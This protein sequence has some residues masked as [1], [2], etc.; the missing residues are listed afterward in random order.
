MYSKNTQDVNQPK[1]QSIPSSITAAKE[2]PVVPIYDL[3][4]SLAERP[5]GLRV[6]TAAAGQSCFQGSLEM[7]Q[8][9]GFQ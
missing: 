6:L 1:R 9:T 4:S 5:G 8:G 2:P 3:P 7:A